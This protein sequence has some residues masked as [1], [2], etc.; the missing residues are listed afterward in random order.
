M[1]KH[2]IGW[3]LV[4]TMLLTGTCG[5]WSAPDQ[6]VVV[7]AALDREFSQPVLDQFAVQSG[8]SVSPKY[9]VES[10]KTVGLVNE[11]LAEKN[12][13]RC[14]V[15]WNNEILHTLRLQ[16][17]GLLEP[18]R[19]PHAA[20]FP[21]SFQSPDGLWYGLAARARVL[22]VNTER[23]TD[24]DRP[25]SVEALA[26]PK[27]KGRAGLAK[28]L[29]GTT[30][31]H[32]AVLFAQWGDERA[33][34]FFTAVRQ[35]AQVLSGNKQVAIAVG[36]GQLDWGLTDTDDAIAEVEAGSPVA[37]V[38]PD[39]AA[40]QPGTLLI[41][42][43]IG[44]IKGCRHPERARQLIDFLL[45]EAVETQLARS[46]SAQFPLR[47]D[48]T[49]RPR[50]EPQPPPRWMEVD[51]AAAADKWDSAAEFLHEAFRGS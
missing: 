12:R 28:P 46:A 7:Y 41:P 31:S 21:A 40:D 4:A 50:V 24:N 37:I 10:T 13:P 22:I 27:W 39:Q 49:A 30:A 5:C 29:F 1:F 20:R 19:S 14:D 6:E 45:T 51:F 17:H 33:R 32:A 23:L 15:F 35:N 16:R 18:Y 2:T 44:I 26:D 47:N 43:T 25:D 34:E 11:I 38:F 3:P 48:V 8:F 9:D 42:N 36:R